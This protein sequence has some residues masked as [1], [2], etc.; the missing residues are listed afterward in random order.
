MASQEAA[1]RTDGQWFSCAA[2][3]ASELERAL[4]ALGRDSP[5]RHRYL[6]HRWINPQPCT[7]G[8]AHELNFLN[9]DPWWERRLETPIGRAVSALF[10]G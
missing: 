3:S 5:E 1:T 8:N 9:L 6:L 7:S 10:D 4:L 2:R